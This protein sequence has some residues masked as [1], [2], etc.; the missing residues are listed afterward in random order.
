M[1][2][3]GGAVH[4]S[5]GPRSLCMEEQERV[6]PRCWSSEPIHPGLWGRFSHQS[7]WAGRPVNPGNLLSTFPQGWNCEVHATASGLLLVFRNWTRD[8]MA[9]HAV[10]CQL[11]IVPAPLENV[12]SL[13]VKGHCFLSVT[14]KGKWYPFQLSAALIISS[15]TQRECG[16]T[17][18]S[19]Y[20]SGN[21]WRE[22]RGEPG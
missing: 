19:D 5:T 22:T 18:W 10:P 11:S 2:L 17:L 16:A 3:W 9:A 13:G 1:C 20:K 4:G 15:I 14:L 6:S 8:F 12:S 7:E 21:P